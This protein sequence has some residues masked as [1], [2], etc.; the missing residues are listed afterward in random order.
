MC[1]GFE[2]EGVGGE[3]EGEEEEGKRWEASFWRR[4]A[5]EDILVWIVVCGLV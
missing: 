5:G 3:G 2:G 1:G 4:V